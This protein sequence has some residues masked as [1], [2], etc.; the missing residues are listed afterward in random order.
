M[1]EVKLRVNLPSDRG[2]VHD[3]PHA[4]DGVVYRG[5]GNR[6]YLILEYVCPHPI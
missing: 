3:V 4:R 5:S 1:G 2:F 6:Y